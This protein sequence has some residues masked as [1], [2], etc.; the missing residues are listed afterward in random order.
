MGPMGPNLRFPGRPGLIDI[1][2][3]YIFFH[4]YMNYICLRCYFFNPVA[5]RMSAVQ[6]HMGYNDIIPKCSLPT[7]EAEECSEVTAEQVGEAA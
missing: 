7:G 4:I 2:I 5:R 1:K 6:T 3:M